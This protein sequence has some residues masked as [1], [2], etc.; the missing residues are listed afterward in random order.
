MSFLQRLLGSL[1][2]PFNK[3]PRPFLALRFRYDG[4]MAWAVRDGVLSTNVS[5]GSGHVLSVDL[6]GYSVA[7]LALYLG[8]QP[9]YSVAYVDGSALAS[10]S[11]LVLVEATGNPD[12][13]N[14]DHLYGYQNANWS[15]LSA[16]AEHLRLASAA[17]VALPAMMSTKT[18]VA[19]WLD[20][21][22]GFYAVARR[23]GEADLQ[24]G[25]RIIASVLQPRSNNVAME[26]VLTKIT[27]QTCAVTDVVL[28]GGALKFDGSV[29][30]DGSET[31]NAVAV[32]VYGLFDVATGYDILG[33]SDPS[34][35]LSLVQDTLS[36][37][38]AAGTRLRSLSL[39][40][41]ALSDTAAGPTDQAAPATVALSVSDAAETPADATSMLPVSVAGIVDTAAAPSDADMLSVSYSTQF[42]GTRHFDGGFQFGAGLTV[43]ETLE[44]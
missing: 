22:G 32:P 36:T 12:L 30:F 24:Y 11:A 9:G 21:L 8:M 7:S 41:S 35:F 2:R 29:H 16:A 1:N 28:Y 37:L 13:S 43:A 18:A 5:G 42:N 40:G 39:S 44:G 20:Y 33:A 15:V 3:D 38:R 27:G 26:A 25:P 6:S 14:G 31:F 17:I 34:G 23:W 4:S 10:L 19:E